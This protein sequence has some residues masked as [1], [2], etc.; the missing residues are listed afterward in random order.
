MVEAVGAVQPCPCGHH[1]GQGVS[2]VP[3]AVSAPC[4][5]TQHG[6]DPAAAVLLCV[7]RGLKEG[8]A[9]C[10]TACLH[11]VFY[12]LSVGSP[13]AGAPPAKAP[14]G[15]GVSSVLGWLCCPHA[16]HTPTRAE[17]LI[18]PSQGPAASQSG[19]RPP[20][21]WAAEKFCLYPCHCLPACVDPCP[22]V[23]SSGGSEQQCL[24]PAAVV[25][26]PNR[27]I[28]GPGINFPCLLLMLWLCC[29]GWPLLPFASSNAWLPSPDSV[30]CSS[31]APAEPLPADRDTATALQ[32][33]TL[34]Q[35]QGN[36][37]AKSNGRVGSPSASLPPAPGSGPQL[38][39]GQ[40]QRSWGTELQDSGSIPRRG[41]TASSSATPREGSSWQG[42]H[43]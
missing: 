40:Q 33:H 21:S 39:S 24:A 7:V 32:E 10:Q 22:R 9:P 25:L 36:I 16:L 34:L 30:P 13:P 23:P 43:V 4:N 38:C 12:P 18:L 3:G 1:P 17:L 8:N 11:L 42:T 29:P 31:H 37:S 26:A 6:T 35:T 20:S 2:P 14:P 5:G 27:S 15:L 28:L 19:D 41:P